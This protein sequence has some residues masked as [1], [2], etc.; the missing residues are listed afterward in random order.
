MLR[1]LA[2]PLLV[3]GVGL[4]A[5]LHFVGPAIE[6]TLRFGGRDQLGFATPNQLWKID[7]TYLKLIDDHRPP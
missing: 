7:L 4:E 1:T 5:L 6:P 3:M 2:I